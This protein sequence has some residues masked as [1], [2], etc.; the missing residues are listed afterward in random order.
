MHSNG[1]QTVNK[2]VL[3]D[4]SRMRRSG[5][6]GRCP[7]CLGRKVVAVVPTRGPSGTRQLTVQVMSPGGGRG[8]GAVGA[9]G[10][11]ATGGPPLIARHVEGMVS[12][13]MYFMFK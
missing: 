9:M 3:P 6:C 11:T 1:N 10:G 12:I 13:R 4:T 8:G 2:L 7:G 5:P